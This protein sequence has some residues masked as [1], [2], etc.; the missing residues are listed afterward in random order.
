MKNL[1]KYGFIAFIVCCL[2]SCT[3]D[4]STIEEED[5]VNRMK[6]KESR[7]IKGYEYIII[8]VDGVEY[9][10]Q[11]GGGFIELTK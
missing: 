8:E 10:S 5:T 9:L 7:I 4:T 1:M 11:L 6:L 3:S 2:S